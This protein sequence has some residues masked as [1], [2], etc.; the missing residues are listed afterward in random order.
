MSL[1]NKNVVEKYHQLTRIDEK[2]A[3]AH[4][5]GFVSATSLFPPDE[6]GS[7]LK[8]MLIPGE[9]HYRIENRHIRIDK[10]SPAWFVEQIANQEKLLSE[11]DDDDLVKFRVRVAG[12]SASGKTAWVIPVAKTFEQAI[13]EYDRELIRIEA[14]PKKVQDCVNWRELATLAY[15]TYAKENNLT[16]VRELQPE[17][18][19]NPLDNVVVMSANGSTLAYLSGAKEIW[20]FSDG[21]EKGT[22]TFQAEINRNIKVTAIS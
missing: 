11:L 15:E 17:E 5:Q 10:R 8:G 1:V 21:I 22:T 6:Q 4:L 2:K 19:G 16:I 13:R 12:W 20:L 14:K 7:R 3:L 9:V 18:P